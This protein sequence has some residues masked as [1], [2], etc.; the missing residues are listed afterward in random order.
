LSTIGAN[1]LLASCVGAILA[2][3]RPVVAG[4]AA[5]APGSAARAPTP[6]PVEDAK[7]AAH[8][9]FDRGLAASND[10]RFGDAAVEFEKAYELFP[11]FRV[12][13]NIGKVRVALGRSAEAIDAFEAY[14]DKGGGEVPE[15]RRQEVRDAI[16]AQMSHVAT[17]AIRVSPDGAE[18]RLDGKL[19]GLSPLPEPLRLTEGKHTVEAMLPGRPVQLRELELPG[20]SALDVTLDFPVA[21]PLAPAPPAALPAPAL[22]A[23]PA[24]REAPRHSPAIGYSLAGA[25]LVA[26]AVGAVLAYEAAQDAN[27][28]RARLVDAATPASGTTTVSDVM[29]YDAAK[30]DYDAAKTRNQLGWALV[31]FGVAAIVGGGALALVWSGSSAGVRG[32]W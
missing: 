23:A 22:V 4:E 8:T 5:P 11:D 3:S 18:L 30:R 19:V 1:L 6:A 13:Y 28:A 12:L 15:E 27:N 10:Q 20:A 21:A 26:T 14:L 24:G 9:H 7:A 31:G 2:L 32:T 29:N 17:L 25:G 16:A